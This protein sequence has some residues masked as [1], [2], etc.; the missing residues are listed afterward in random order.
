MLLSTPIFSTSSFVFLIPAVST[1]FNGM[2]FIFMYS[3]I[4]SLVVPSISLTIAL[5]SP[6]IK[7]KRDDLPT[8]GFPIIAVLIPSFKILPFSKLFFNFN[9]FSSTLFNVSFIFLFVVSS[10]SYSG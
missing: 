8:F 7:F 3:S 4:V 5:F 1:I 2:P 9:N 6:S 10:M